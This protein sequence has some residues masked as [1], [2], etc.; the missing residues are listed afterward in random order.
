[1][2][3]RAGRPC[4]YITTRP[5]EKIVTCH[6][7]FVNCKGNNIDVVHNLSCHFEQSEKSRRVPWQ[8]PCARSLGASLCRDDTIDETLV[9]VDNCYII[10]KKNPLAINLFHEIALLS[11]SNSKSCYLNNFFLIIQSI[12]LLLLVIRGVVFLRQ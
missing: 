9:L 5:R 12:G 6:L 2:L 3:A 4:P 1:M 10:S 11:Q 7:S 8:S